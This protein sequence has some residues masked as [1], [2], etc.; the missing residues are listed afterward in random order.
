MSTYVLPRPRQ[1]RPPSLPLWTRGDLNA[2]FGL[3]HQHARQRARARRPVGRRRRASRATTS[4]GTIL[5]ALGIEL[6]VGNLFYFLLARRLAAK[7]GRTDVTAM[8]YGPS[9]PHMFIVTFVIMLPTYLQ[10]KD[11]VKAW[12]AGL[13]W[14][15][16]IGVIILIGAFVGPVR[17]ASS[18]RAP[19]CSARWRAS[20]SRS[21]RC[22]RRRRCGRRRGSRC[23]CSRSSSS[24]SSSGVRLPGNFPIGL[25]ALLLG[26]A[27]GW[28]GGFMDGAR[29][30]TAPSEIAVGLPSLNFDLLGNGLDGISPLLATAIPLGIYNFTEAMSNVESAAA[31]GDKYNL[32]AR[33]ARR[34][35]GRDRR[36]LPRQPVPAGRLRRPAGLEGRRRPHQLLAG[37]RRRDLPALRARACSR[38]S[39]RSCRSRRSSRSCCSSASSSARRR[40]ARCRRPTT[41]RSCWR[42]SRTWRPGASGR[43]TTRCR[44]PGTS[45]RAGRHAKLAAAG[46]IYGGMNT[47]GQ[48]RCWRAW[49]SARSRSS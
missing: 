16:I 25:A 1:P 45:A 38:C 27:I 22:A 6:L 40:S 2:F 49:C 10:T 34:R 11:P 9:V 23:R 47:L 31:A 13:A 26:T 48:G 44:R 19:R 3:G 29:S 4:T 24:A 30:A 28:I 39:A 21:S 37:D 18:R 20:R 46:T 7:E 5:P 15:F 36:L 14:A 41:R 17:S 42:W 43:S 12:E 8:P 35:H 33:P 32:R